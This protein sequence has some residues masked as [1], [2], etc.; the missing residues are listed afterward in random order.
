MATELFQ[1]IEQHDLGRIAG[2]LVGGANP[3]A[4]E[5]KRRGWT[6]LHSAIEELD[7]GGSIDVLPLLLEHGANVNGWDALHEASPLLMACFR[8]NK[9]AA[10]ILL[11]A[12]ADPNVRSGQGDSPLRW[13]V[14][15]QDQEMAALLLRFGA[16]ESIDEFGEPRGW[17]ALG[18]AASLLNIPMIRLLLDGGADPE[19]PDEDF[20][21]A[22]ERFPP[23]DK[24]DPEVWDTALELLALRTA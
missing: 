9:E 10:S 5:A 7:Y 12:G 11:N 13:S 15:E 8:N 2:L 6:P 14:D 16:G 18:V 23:R 21:T 1:A 4:T 19:A 17:T 20:K 22:R 24:S 3:N